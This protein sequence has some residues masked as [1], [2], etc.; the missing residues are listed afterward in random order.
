MGLFRSNKR[1]CQ[2]L[3]WQV[4]WLLL[5][6]FLLLFWLGSVAVAS[7]FYKWEDENGVIHYGDK[8][9]KDSQKGHTTLNDQG[10]TVDS[11][12][13]AKTVEELAAEE[14]AK[15]E[16]RKKHQAEMEARH[17]D[18]VLLK[19]FTTERDLLLTRDDRLAAID[20]AI[21]LSERRIRSWSEK[22]SQVES[23]IDQFEAEDEVPQ[24]LKEE[25]EK[26][27]RNIA[28]SDAYMQDKMEER[29]RTAQQ[30]KED[31]ARYRELKTE[32]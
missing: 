7:D 19:T 30:F 11:L 32:E 10:L 1:R 8:P 4:A 3:A 16:A 6:A 5:G 28:N 23:R 22:L 13:R 9:P 26:L 20:S 21:L 2:L 17:R 24:Q 27:E 18:N 29:E 15:E 25:R 12:D 14:L 31:L